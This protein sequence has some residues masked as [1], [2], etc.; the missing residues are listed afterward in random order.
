MDTW[1]SRKYLSL[2]GGHTEGKKG[3]QTPRAVLFT[4]NR[5]RCE[6][7]SEDTCLKVVGVE[8]SEDQGPY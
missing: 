8:L 4:A 1:G 7:K 5:C 6:H 2:L 3:A